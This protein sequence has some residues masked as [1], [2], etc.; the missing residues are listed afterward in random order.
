MSAGLEVIA[1]TRRQNGYGQAVLDIKAEFLYLH[2]GPSIHAEI[3]GA[4]RSPDE[5]SG[6]SVSYGWDGIWGLKKGGERMAI[7]G[8]GVDLEKE[9][10]DTDDG[11]FLFTELY[12]DVIVQAID[13]AFEDEE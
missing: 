5:P 12:G 7:D 8:A 9:M 3:V 10:I 13:E 1:T 2:V 4:T 11:E 6:L